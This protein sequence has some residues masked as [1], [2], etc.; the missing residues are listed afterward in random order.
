MKSIIERN[1]NELKI[2]V[3]S[4]KHWGV[5]ITSYFVLIVLTYI[6]ISLILSIFF[7]HAPVSGF[8]VLLVILLFYILLCRYILWIC[9][10]KEIFYV[11]DDKVYFENKAFGLGSQTILDK[12]KVKN[13]RYNLIQYSIFSR[14]NMKM[15]GLIDGK[16]KFDHEQ[17]TYSFALGVD[18]AETVHIVKILK[19]KFNEKPELF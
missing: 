7:N 17:L 6:C 10:G 11:K 5:I 14:S 18:D 16:V 9:W 1:N 12:A 2:T 19:E 3:S 13:F 8:G 15:F 4:Y